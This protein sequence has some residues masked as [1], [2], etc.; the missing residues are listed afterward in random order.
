MGVRTFLSL[1]VYILYYI[2]VTDVLKT[3]TK[4]VYSML[5]LKYIRKTSE[6]YAV[7]F[8][9][10]LKVC[11]A[12]M[13]DEILNFTFG[14]DFSKSADNNAGVTFLM[15]RHSSFLIAVTQNWL[16]PW[17]SASRVHFLLEL[18]Q[19]QCGS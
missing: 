2:I 1:A 14:D 18:H 19:P 5:I 6:V 10:I 8:R 13:L 7:Q 16:F 12:I 3:D 9:Y 4:K 11:I 17:H 15:A